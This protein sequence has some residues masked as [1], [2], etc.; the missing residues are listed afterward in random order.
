MIVY[1]LQ[2]TKLLRVTN[3]N[4]SFII[5]KIKSRLAGWKGI[6]S[7]NDSCIRRLLV[8]EGKFSRWV[9]WNTITQPYTRGGLG[10]KRARPVIVSILGKYVWELLHN[11]DKLWVQLLSAKYNF[12][13]DVLEAN[14]YHGASY[15]WCSI[16]KAVEAPSPESFKDNSRSL[17]NIL[18]QITALLHSTKHVSC[19]SKIL[20]H[21]LVSWHPSM[22]NV[23]KINVDGSFI[24]N[25][26]SSGFVGLLRNP[27]GV[28]LQVLHEV[29]VSPIIL[30]LELQVIS[31]WLDIAWNHG[32]RNVIC[33]SDS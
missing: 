15:T 4:F 17:W 13:S 12:V 14:N 26:G 23:I 21:R 19:D 10:I 3:E 11:P 24:S 5:D 29:V 1:Y 25:L 30:N 31:H 16:A 8:W 2:E 9:T 32:F 20:A 27:Y 6:C 22:E 28:G 18:S 33:E 7:K